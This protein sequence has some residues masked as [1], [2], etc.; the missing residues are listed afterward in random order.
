M[1]PYEPKLVRQAIDETV[2][3]P[4]ERARLGLRLA[5]VDQ[6]PDAPWLIAVVNRGTEPVRVIPDLR[7]LS[8]EITPPA[9]EPVKG[10]RKPAAPK[11]VT[12]TL[13]R[14]LFPNEE[15][16]ALEQVLKPGEGL[17]DSFDPRL[18]CLSKHGASPLTPQATVV[19]R[20][21]WP[22]KT[23]S[24]WKQG[25]RQQVVLEQTAP[26][27]ARRD[28]PEGALPAAPATTSENPA[29][30][31]L[32]PRS[33]ADAVKQLIATPISLGDSYKKPEAVVDTEPL[34][35]VLSRGSDARTEADATITVAL[36]S[37]GKKP[38][39]VFFRRELVSFEVS[40]PSDVFSCDPGPDARVPDRQSLVTLR[41]GKRISAVSRLIE[42][43]PQGAFRRPGLYLV[44][45]RYDS[46]SA[47]DSNAPSF[48]QG[49]LVS[50]EPVVVRIHR[51]WGDLPPQRQP[52]RFEIGQ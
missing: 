11:P 41:P 31:T 5:I 38:E 51:G 25:Q 44:H 35:L 8:L 16:P 45:G 6:G 34:R 2:A 19:A 24:V 29:Q 22:E 7:T 40:G 30:P 47:D 1:V 36:V 18:Y 37:Q 20:L 28:M 48:Y 42:L 12:C 39:R 32:A 33:D 27:I 13:P 46:T 21:G 50:H 4:D 3:P 49:R 26:F 9:P 52:Q 14:D 15:D 10:K 17:A 43:C 23:K